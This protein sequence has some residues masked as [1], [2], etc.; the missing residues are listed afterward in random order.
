VRGLSDALA[1]PADSEQENRG[2]DRYENVVEAR[3]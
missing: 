1:D 2:G 3:D